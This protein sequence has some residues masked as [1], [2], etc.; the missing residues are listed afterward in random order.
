MRI[1]WGMLTALLACA[2]H[3]TPGTTATVPPGPALTLDEVYVSEALEL[4]RRLAFTV[5]PSAPVE[6]TCRDPADPF[7][8]HRV[9][10]PAA[11]APVVELYGLLADL[12]YACEARAT[13]VD[14]GSSVVAFELPIGSL[15][16][17]LRPFVV[18]GDPD[19]TL[20]AWTLL[21][22]FDNEFAAV[23]DHFL[24]V[25]DPEGRVRW[26]H[27]LGTTPSSDLDFRW[28]GDGTFLYG[29]AFGI[30]PTLVG[31]DG[32]VRWV[33]G[34]PSGGG[35]WHHHAERD[36]DGTVLGM[37]TAITSDGSAWMGFTVD[38]VDPASNTIAWSWSS[39]QGYDAGSL[40]AG[41]TTLDPYHLNSL[42]VLPDDPTG[43]WLSLRAMS[44]VVRLDTATGELG[45]AFGPGTDVV[46]LDEEGEVSDD[47]FYQPHAP[48][49]TRN[50][51]GTLTVLLH[52]NGVGRPGS[53]Y[54]RAAEYLV[55]L[56]ARTARLT[57]SWTEEGWYELIWGDADRLV[58]GDEEHVLV[59]KGHCASCPAP[60]DDETEVIE[61][62]RATGEAVWRLRSE[63]PFAGLYRADRVP[64]CELFAHAGYCPDVR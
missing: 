8:A 53:D 26:Y 1:Q 41:T 45:H 7:E 5:E 30:N 60:T 31:L 20:G 18:V 59:A 4:A 40:P 14:G 23:L 19:A 36:V 37:G 57:W 51:D 63:L 17:S 13:G 12:T 15:P 62:D 35:V 50:P 10:V 48:E 6:V 28:L 24:V 64:S 32:G 34:D 38:R 52:D 49:L 54:S 29:G 46:L 25:V 27:G 11:E 2:A 47:W 22:L 16:A 61:V 44:Q 58:Q 21:N 56:E 55:N 39:Q 9:T 43:V 42:S 3:P 33:A